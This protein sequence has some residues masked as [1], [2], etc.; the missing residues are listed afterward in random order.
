MADEQAGLEFDRLIG[1][2]PRAEQAPT[3]AALALDDMGTEFDRLVGANAPL[4]NVNATP[5]PGSITPP[6]PAMR[7]MGLWAEDIGAGARAL[8]ER[9]AQ[10]ISESQV[11]GIP[12]DVQ[13][14]A[15]ALTRLRLGAERNKLQQLE[16][17]R[18][19]YG[20][21]VR[22][23]KEGRWIVR[24]EQD[25]R[26]KDVLVDEEA[27]TVKD[28]ADV[29][30]KA[31][32]LALSIMATKG[33]PAG[34]IFKSAVMGALG[35]AGGE[36]A[37]DVAARV[38]RPGQLQPGEIATKRGGQAILDTAFGYG[39]GRTINAMGTLG[40]LLRMA[41]SDAP[42]MLGE[43]A[44]AVARQRVEQ[45]RQ[46]TQTLTGVRLEPTLGELTGNPVI[47][48]LEAFF[49]NIPL[50][51]GFI[52]RNIERRMAN[53]RAI[54]IELFKMAGGG[55]ADLPDVTR[56]GEDVVAALGGKLRGLSA[57]ADELAGTVRREAT[58]T[59]TEP[60]EQI[61]GA[62]LS[63]S[64]FGSRMIRRGEAQLASFKGRA[65]E[66]YDQFRNLP[67]ANQ[68]LFDAMPVQNRAAALKDELVKNMQG[69]V[70]K[71]LAP[72]GVTAQLDA[73]DRLPS[74]M[75]YFDLVKLRNS[76][77][78]R[79]GS[80]EPIS[81]RGE[82]ILKDVGASITKELQT[83][84]PKVFGQNWKLVENATRYYRE[85]VETF[86]QKG[87]VGMLKP[88]TE[89]GAIDPER[90]ASNLLAG[91]KGSVTTYNTFRDFF[92]KSGAVK[93]MNRLLRD[94]IIDT[95]TDKATGL[96][97]LEDLGAAVGKLE[98]EIVRSLYGVPKTELLRSVQEAQVGLRSIGKFG[99]VPERGTQ[100][101]V[102][103]EALKEALA[104]GTVKSGALKA[105]VT[106]TA[107]LERTYHTELVK[108]LTQGDTRL[109]EA[110]PEKFV[111]SFLLNPATTE[112]AAQNAMQ[113]L[114]ATGD[115]LLVGDVRRL[116]LAD[117]FKSGAASAAG[118]VQQLVS[119]QTGS[120][121][122]NLDPQKFAVVLE[123]EAVQ[124][125]MN[126][127][128]GP[129]L[130]KGVREFGIALSGR[131]GRDAAAT[132]TASF[133]GGSYTH[134]IIQL[135]GGRWGAIKSLPDLAQYRVM[136]YLL[137]HPDSIKT[138]RTLANAV[139]Q[140]VGAVAKAMTLTPEF[141]H[142]LASDSTTPEE[143]AQVTQEIQQWATQQGEPNA[144]QTR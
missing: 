123:N 134:Q 1:A 115:D 119:M 26:P 62:P 113:H 33:L 120:P 23:D 63:A 131:A 124:K 77:Y 67:E 45:G 16:K 105:L 7:G 126:M 59:L 43:G 97:K 107:E 141:A 25:G 138:L 28:L 133:V 24:T 30:H 88:R 57:Q 68:P 70:E 47:Q 6:N 139:P 106:T 5:P 55:V 14:G 86:Y 56:L 99:S 90:I 20:D 34:A 143:A 84:G 135:L 12:L 129:E 104:S 31:P 19:Q 75:S 9:E 10:T 95:G 21:A 136:S 51:R 4:A 117:L 80:P 118:D 85:N 53:E 111:R 69:G 46:A 144:P 36:A 2:G 98:P 93:D 76:I 110:A 35:W 52:L 122:R 54:Q 81:S 3:N 79:I 132:T 127:I 121:L 40:R 38:G 109:I 125:R 48:R 60:L 74:D 44:T 87:I 89:A 108:A 37:V 140:D 103:A 101:A 96:I 27:M 29:A 128:L 114:V 65:E 94:Q 11:P 72:T 32:A 61:T 18:E 112:K 58:E 8:A 137:T 78:D 41:S 49:S 13:S 73:I 83:Q 22:M 142:A 91:G 15:D 100:A 92:E 64:S 71:A 17:L 82:R 116:Y 66:L 130:A 42:T 50:A 102:E 39:I